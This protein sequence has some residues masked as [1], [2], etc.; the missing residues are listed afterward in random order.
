M[1]F[2]SQR[3]GEGQTVAGSLVQTSLW[4]QVLNIGSIANTTQETLDVHTRD[5]PRSALVNQYKAG[6]GKW[7]TIAGILPRYWP[8]FVEAVGIQHIQADSRFTT[9]EDMQKNSSELVPLLDQ[10]F[11]SH[12][13]DYWIEQM[14]AR[15]LWCGR[16]NT[17]ADVL[18]DEHIEANGY[19]TQLDDGA[20]TVT[21]P[22]TLLGYTP[23]T[24]AGPALGEHT[25]EVLRELGIDPANLQGAGAKA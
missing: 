18:T 20:R 1:L 13:A 14:L 16:C 19:L 12:P 9:F 22:F 6:D 5:H 11:L 10:H 7:F 15:G 4:A 8:I 23:P 21:M 25:E 3:T 17:L 2:R 24:E